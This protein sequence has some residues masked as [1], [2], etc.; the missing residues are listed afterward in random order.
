MNHGVSLRA[1]YCVHMKSMIRE[2]LPSQ[3]CA[4][5]LGQ[6]LLALSAMA[7]CILHRSMCVQSQGYCAAVQCSCAVQLCSAA[8]GHTARDALDSVHTRIS[9]IPWLLHSW[10]L[11]NAFKWCM[12]TTFKIHSLWATTLGLFGRKLKFLWLGNCDYA[13]DYPTEFFVLTW[14]HLGTV[15]KNGT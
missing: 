12:S 4:A 7:T 6:Q 8:Q 3:N 5:V 1:G 13:P 9:I 11:F 14:R 10:E 15:D 2:V